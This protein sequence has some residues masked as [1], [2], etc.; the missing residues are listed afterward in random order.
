MDGKVSICSKW[1]LMELRDRRSDPCWQTYKYWKV[2]CKTFDNGYG[3]SKICSNWPPT[4]L[5]DLDITFYEICVGQNHK[6]LLVPKW[7]SL[8]KTVLNFI[9]GFE[10]GEEHKQTLWRAVQ[11]VAGIDMKYLFETFGES[12]K[13]SILIF[14]QQNG[15]LE[16]YMEKVFFSK[17]YIFL[18]KSSRWQNFNFRKRC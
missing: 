9:G 18:Q 13:N 8:Q 3:C 11:N 12:K 7:Q 5:L 14:L 4:I 16:K 10:F 6:N 17:S 15:V 2:M 1:S